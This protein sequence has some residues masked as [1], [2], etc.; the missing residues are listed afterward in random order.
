MFKDDVWL[1]WFFLVIV[2]KGGVLR[3]NEIRREVG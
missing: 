3:K 1:K 2:W